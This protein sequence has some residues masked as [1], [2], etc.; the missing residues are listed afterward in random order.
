VLKK[1]RKKMV[2]SVTATDFLLKLGVA[3]ASSAYGRRGRDVPAA[4]TGGYPSLLLPSDFTQINESG[5][6]DAAN[7][8]PWSMVFWRN[9]L[10]VGT[11]RAF[12]CVEYWAYHRAFPLISPYPPRRDP[13][14]KCPDSAYDLPLQA[15]IWAYAPVEHTWSRVFRSPKDVSCVH[16]SDGR[17]AS[18]IGFRNMLVFPEKNGTEALYVFG[19]SPRPIDRSLPGPRILRSEDGAN[20]E[21]VSCARGTFMGDLDAVGFRA[22]AVYKSRLFVAAGALWGEGVLLES[23][24]PRQ[25]GNSFCQVLPSNVRVNEMVVF[26]AWLYLGLRDELHGYSVVK[27]NAEGGPPYKIVPVFRR[28]SAWGPFRQTTVLAL[29]VFQDRLFVGTDNPAEVVAIDAHDEAELIIGRARRVA[30]RLLKPA[31]SLGPGLNY[32]LNVEFERMEVHDGCLYL[33]TT[34]LTGKFRERSFAKKLTGH[35]GF[36]LYATPDGAAFE[37]ITQNGFGDAFG[38][39]IRTFASTPFGLF[40]GAIS[41]K[42]GARVFLGSKDGRF[43]SQEA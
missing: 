31:S 35:M 29:C 14:V 24:D 6:G 22:A 32:R 43:K 17:V 42:T 21:T 23:S 5:F 12:P 4:G 18:D 30:G 8:Y 26:N 20:F 38:G 27:I 9:R 41:E 34:N 15:E 1:L 16:S 13:D 10:Y 3:V 25:G 11:N 7:T 19:V 37:R 39:T 2:A 36:D 33:S 40:A 28:G